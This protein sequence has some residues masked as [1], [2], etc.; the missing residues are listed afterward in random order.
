MKKRNRLYEVY[1][2]ILIKNLSNSNVVTQCIRKAYWSFSEDDALDQFSDDWTQL[3][4][5]KISIE[6]DYSSI[7]RRIV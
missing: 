2:E 5:E 6:F 1:G 4:N 3:W 7:E